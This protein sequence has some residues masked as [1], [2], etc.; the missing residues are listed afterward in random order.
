MQK[1]VLRRLVRE[2]IKKIIKEIS[3]TDDVQGVAGYNAFSTKDYD[4]WRREK[5]IEINKLL[6]YKTEKKK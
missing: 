6:K 3:Q 5:L 1:S 2:E 4:S